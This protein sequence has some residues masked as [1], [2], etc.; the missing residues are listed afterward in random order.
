[1]SHKWRLQLTCFFPVAESV[2]AS[3]H[4]GASV[5]GMDGAVAGAALLGLQ[6]TRGLGRG[7]DRSVGECRRGLRAPVSVARIRTVR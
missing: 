5:G 4:L 6:R 2:G 1:M 3:G 7:G